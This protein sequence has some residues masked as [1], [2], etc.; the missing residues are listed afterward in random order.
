[1]KFELLYTDK[2]CDLRFLPLGTWWVIVRPK[3]VARNFELECSS[4]IH[5]CVYIGKWLYLIE[6]QFKSRGRVH[7]FVSFMSS[8]RRSSSCVR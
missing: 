2:Q 4:Q 7:V 1:M 5:H 8:S 6:V 3:V